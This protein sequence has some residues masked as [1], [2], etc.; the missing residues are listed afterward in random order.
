MTRPDTDPVIENLVRLLD[1]QEGRGPV[2]PGAESSA[3]SALSRA[4]YFAVEGDE[5]VGDGLVTASQVLQKCAGSLALAG[6]PVGNAM[7][8]LPWLQ[9]EIGVELDAQPVGIGLETRLVAT[10]TGHGLSVS[11]VAPRVHWGAADAAFLLVVRGASENVHLLQVPTPRPQEVSVREWEARGGVAISTVSC[12]DHVPS[13]DMFRPIDPRQLEELRARTMLG[14]T[15]HIAGV[16]ERVTDLTLDYAATRVQF[17]KPIGE[18]Q[19]VKS[20]LAA[21][22]SETAATL[23]AA[24]TAAQA[25]SGSD[26]STAP[27]ATV[28]GARLRGAKA[29]TAA[30]RIA[31]QVHGT[32]G[33]TEEHPLHLLTGQL[34]SLRD[35]GSAE[36]SVETELGQTLLAGG[37]DLFL[38]TLVQQWE[39]SLG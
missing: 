20:H 3:W 4:G 1:D 31:H 24:S 25:L 22:I 10:N 34:W 7:V 32:I 28:L 26:G 23:A 36:A 11:G 37:R 30:A 21:L 5:E 8:V 9:R 18:F 13:P 39:A 27:M 15:L 35:A 2:S 6:Q 19:M 17:G 14:V 29:A 12:H 38:S 33:V 16:L